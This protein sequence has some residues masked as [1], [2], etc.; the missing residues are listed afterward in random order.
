[1]PTSE[2]KENRKKARSKVYS[3]HSQLSGSHKP[4][5]SAIRNPFS[6]PKHSRQVP[7]FKLSQQEAVTGQSRNADFKKKYTVTQT[8]LHHRPSSQ[9]QAVPSKKTAQPSQQNRG[10]KAYSPL[11]TMGPPSTQQSQDLIKKTSSYKRL[12]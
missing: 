9:N 11:R 4:S 10:S 3:P 5:E 12:H 6:P 8:I 2:R 7:K 1:M